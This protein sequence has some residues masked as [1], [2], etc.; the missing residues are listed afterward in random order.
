[1]GTCAQHM[2]P[3]MQPLHIHTCTCEHKCARTHVGRFC[4]SVCMCICVYARGFCKFTHAYTGIDLYMC[5]CVF[6]HACTCMWHLQVH[7]HMQEC[8]C[9]PMCYA[10]RRFASAHLCVRSLHT[11]TGACLRAYM[12][13]HVCACGCVHVCIARLCSCVCIP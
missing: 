1:M 6:V 7:T 13:V 11:H 12:C 8:L 3:C 2:C 9:V 10:C 4:A 5:A